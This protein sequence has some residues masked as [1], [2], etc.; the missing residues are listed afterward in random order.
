MTSSPANDLVWLSDNAERNIAR[1][2]HILNGRLGDE[3]TLLINF[4]LPFGN[5]CAYF[6]VPSL[7]G[8]PH[9]VTNAWKAFLAG[10][11]EHRDSRLK[12][13]TVIT[14]GGPWIVQ[15]AVGPGTSPALLGKAIPLQYFFSKPLSEKKGVYEVDVIIT[16]SRVASEYVLSMIIY[17][18]PRYYHFFSSL[19]RH[20]PPSTLFRRCCIQRCQ[21]SREKS[22][23]CFCFY[24]RG[25]RKRR[26]A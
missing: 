7:E 26:I 3:E 18:A 10:D 16:A 8:L 24:H 20:I 1:H 22:E 25:C 6:R 9:N 15:K 13:L 19:L 11:Q 21:R 17:C 5:L 2:P 12:M 4:C 14:D 23:Y